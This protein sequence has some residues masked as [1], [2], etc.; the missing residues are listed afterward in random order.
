MNLANYTQFYIIFTYAFST[1]HTIG[2]LLLKSLRL[3]AYE[4]ELSF[5]DTA[6]LFAICFS[7]VINQEGCGLSSCILPITVRELKFFK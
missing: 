5:L 4:K 3:C 7:L 2:N 6:T 1:A